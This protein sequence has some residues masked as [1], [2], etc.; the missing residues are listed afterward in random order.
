[1]GGHNA[2]LPAVSLCGQDPV[3]PRA[4]PVPESA[5]PG[6]LLHPLPGQLSQLGALPHRHQENQGR[7]HWQ[8]EEQKELEANISVMMGTTLHVAAQPCSDHEVHHSIKT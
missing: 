8:Q 6:R 1:M 7:A 3:R 5:L 4:R 2:A